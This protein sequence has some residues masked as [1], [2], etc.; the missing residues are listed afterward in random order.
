MLAHEFN[1]KFVCH[2][3]IC[4][5]PMAEYLLR[6]YVEEA[7]LGGNISVKSAGIDGRFRGHYMHEGTW[8]V[9]MDH[10][11]ESDDFISKNI[12][13]S[14]AITY[15]YL[16]AMDDDVLSEARFFY[17]NSLSEGQLF[18]F[19]ELVPGLGYDGVPDP[20]ITHDFDETYRIISTGCR[21]LLERIR[22][23]MQKVT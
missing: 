16:V 6:S 5:S 12:Q 10:G 23:D 15:R 22:E 11:I 20:I 3:N 19:T 8:N 18:K 4:R 9:L 2:A 13:E 7:G 1:V 14:D 17:G 21:A